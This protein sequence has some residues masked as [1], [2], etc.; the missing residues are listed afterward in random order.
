MDRED[1]IYDWMNTHTTASFKIFD[2]ADCLALV[3]W[4]YAKWNIQ[5]YLKTDIIMG[6]EVA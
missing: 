3:E 4:H 1:L 2:F 5:W 6:D